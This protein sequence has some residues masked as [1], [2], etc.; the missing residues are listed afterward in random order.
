MCS[1]SPFLF[2]QDGPGQLTVS[3]LVL[4]SQNPLK[5]HS[6]HHTWSYKDANNRNG[7]T[8]QT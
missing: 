1:S 5:L 6:L 2:T 4:D 3:K 8:G 7:E